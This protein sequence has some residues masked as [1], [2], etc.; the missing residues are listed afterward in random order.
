VADYHVTGGEEALSDLAVRVDDVAEL[1][2]L[3]PELLLKT[4]KN[5]SKLTSGIFNC[6]QITCGHVNVK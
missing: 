1:H 5:L 4:A 3:L 6:M 2:L